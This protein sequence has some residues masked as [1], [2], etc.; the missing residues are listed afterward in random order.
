MT[1]CTFRRPVH[2]TENRL[3]HVWC[4]NYEARTSRCGQ[5]CPGWEEPNGYDAVCLLELVCAI[6]RSA[7]DQNQRSAA[8]QWAII[9]GF[10][11]QDAEYEVK[12]G[13]AFRAGIRPK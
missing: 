5:D 2:S 1:D 8:I 6:I 10:S 13:A 7:M 11:P 12:A 4:T 3:L 9:G